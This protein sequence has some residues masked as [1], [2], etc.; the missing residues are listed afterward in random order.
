[1]SD[2]YAMLGNAMHYTAQPEPEPLTPMLTAATVSPL[3]YYLASGYAT[4]G[5]SASAGVAPTG[6]PPPVVTGPAA[7]TIVDSIPYVEDGD[8]IRA[9]DHNDLLSAI[10]LIARLLDT[11]ELKQEI[12]VS[13]APVLLPV[14]NRE[15]FQLDEGFAR[16]PA[17]DV[18]SF[19]GWMPLDLPDGYTIDSLR[20]R[21]AYPGGGLADWPVSLRRVPHGKQDDETV[22]SGNL[23]SGAT[24]LGAAFDSP[25][26]FDSRGHSLAEADELS[27]VDTSRFRYQFHTTVTTARPS[28]DVKLFSVQ[29]DCVKG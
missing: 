8:V 18:A 20:L 11:G 15:R 24:T 16:G 25:F 9:R 5:P 13:A 12:T 14:L 23:K 2:I 29:V 28:A 22:I 27:K 10:R 7:A 4:A 3:L 19:V 1:M 17:A 26:A 6:A 21:G